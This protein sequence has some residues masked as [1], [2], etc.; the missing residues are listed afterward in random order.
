ML[1]KVEEA[2]MAEELAGKKIIFVLGET[3]FLLPQHSFALRMNA[4]ALFQLKV[5]FENVAHE[6]AVYGN[7]NSWSL[8]GNNENAA[9]NSLVQNI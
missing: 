7:D 1:D 6:E 9:N 8:K 2:D 4:K 5:F 3:Y